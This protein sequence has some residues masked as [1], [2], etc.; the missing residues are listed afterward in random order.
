MPGTFAQ[1][2]EVTVATLRQKAQAPPTAQTLFLDAGDELR[3]A[4]LLFVT[5]QIEKDACIAR[6]RRKQPC[7]EEY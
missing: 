2:E 5:Q 4:I 3:T 6:Q 7:V 1:D